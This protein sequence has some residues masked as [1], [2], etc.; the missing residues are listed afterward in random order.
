[1]ELAITKT[2]K[3]EI[4]LFHIYRSVRAREGSR[5]NKILL[6]DKSMMS[7]H[8]EVANAIKSKTRALPYLRQ[9]GVE[10]GP[11]GGLLSL[12]TRLGT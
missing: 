5:R 3:C 2:V 6:V 1:M 11:D 12:A 10:C 4:R 9:F 8:N 7:G